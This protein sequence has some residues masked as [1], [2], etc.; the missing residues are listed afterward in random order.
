MSKFRVILFVLRYLVSRD[1]FR[2]LLDSRTHISFGVYHR[3]NGAPVMHAFKV[4]QL[5]LDDLT[6]SGNSV[7][8][9]VQAD[10]VREVLALRGS[11]SLPKEQNGRLYERTA[12]LVEAREQGIDDFLHL[13]TLSK[14]GRFDID[15]GATRACVLALSGASEYKAVVAIRV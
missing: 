4:G 12:A 2:A 5:T 11:K 13:V 6:I 3:H 1:F 14:D 8:S 10:R 9:S 7:L 15:D